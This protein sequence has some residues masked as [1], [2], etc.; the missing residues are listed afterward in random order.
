M[1]FDEDIAEAAQQADTGRLVI[2][3][4]TAAAILAQT[5]AQ[6]QRF[7]RLDHNPGFVEDGKG[8]MSGGEIEFSDGGSFIGAGTDKAALGAFANG[9]SKG[10]EQNGFSGTGLTGQGAKTTVKAGIKAI[11]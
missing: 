7:A 10:T 4:G 8:R 11:N 9:Q 1:H 2:D 6:D 5:T 3:V